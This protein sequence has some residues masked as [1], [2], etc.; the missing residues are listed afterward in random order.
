MASTVIS[1]VK[2][3]QFE[4]KISP[5]PYRYRYRRGV[6]GAGTDI[7]PVVTRGDLPAPRSPP[8]RQ[9]LERYVDPHRRPLS[10]CAV[11]PGEPRQEPLPRRPARVHLDD[12]A[13]G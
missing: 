11:D 7:D 5:E 4:L 13:T 6:G 2:T 3:V 10:G 1:S 8:G 12:V 9:P